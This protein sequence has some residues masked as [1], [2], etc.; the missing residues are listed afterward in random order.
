MKQLRACVVVLLLLA[1]ILVAFWLT[2]ASRDAEAGG[3]QPLSPGEKTRLMVLEDF[4]ENQAPSAPV[5]GRRD[6]MFKEM[7]AK[8]KKLYDATVLEYADL[9]VRPPVPP[10]CVGPRQGTPYP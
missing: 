5:Q 6:A 10:P 4:D 1:G 9:V 7:V 3:F 8:R 2:S